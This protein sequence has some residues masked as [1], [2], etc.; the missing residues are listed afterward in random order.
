MYFLCNVAFT[1]FFRDKTNH[2]RG[3]TATLRRVTA[4]LTP[5]RL[6]FSHKMAVSLE[7]LQ[8]VRLCI[9]R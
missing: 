8:K 3:N 4:S 5:E 7:L 2:Y 9:P 1:G 6:R